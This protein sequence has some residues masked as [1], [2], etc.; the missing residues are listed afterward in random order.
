MSDDRLLEHRRIWRDKPVLA[1]VYRVWFDDLLAALGSPRR[2]LELGAGPGF[3][4]EYARAH[5]PQV[6]WVALDILPTPWNDVVGDGLRLPFPDG[7]FD[8]V[9]ALDFIH[10]L[11]RPK[12][13]FEEAARVLRP[14]GR[15]A[16]VEPW[17]TPFSFPIYRWL[18]QEGCRPGLDPWCPFGAAPKDAFDGDAAVVWKLVR[19]TTAAEWRALGFEPPR[20]S[21]RNAFAYLPSLGFRPGSLLPRWAVRPLQALDSA[22]DVCAPVTGL[23]ARVVWDRR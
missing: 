11:A 18:H 23:R 4:S 9:A 17:V 8:A 1:E 12:L 10:H 2:V 5:L 22:L 14:E 7:A 21:P 3:L 6:H 13:F 16:A 15:V 20:A 19:G